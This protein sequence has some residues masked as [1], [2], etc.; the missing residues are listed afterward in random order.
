[1]SAVKKRVRHTPE[2]I[3]VKL[4]EADE[5]PRLRAM[6]AWGCQ[7]PCYG[8]RMIHALLMADGFEVGPDRVYRLW[9]RH[10]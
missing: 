6:E 9:R 4:R 8:Y 7:H 1:M 2:Q 10:G 3:I 5:G